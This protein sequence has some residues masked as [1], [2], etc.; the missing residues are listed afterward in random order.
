MA[1]CCGL[2]DRGLRWSVPGE[3]AFE[4][5]CECFWGCA[6]VACVATQAEEGEQNR[7]EM[8]Q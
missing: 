8:I 1:D 3:G 5:V 7:V 4:W 6:C 2:A